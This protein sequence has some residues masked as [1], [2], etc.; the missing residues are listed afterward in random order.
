MATTE[1][2]TEPRT[3]TRTEP[4]AVVRRW[5]DFVDGAWVDAASGRT[6]DVVD[7]A[8]G[9]VVATAPVSGAA[10]VDA[11]YDAA[12]RAFETWRDTT[13]AEMQLALLRIADFLAAR[14]AEFAELEGQ[15]TG[16]PHARTAS[17]E[18]PRCVDQLR[19]FAGATRVLEWKSAGEYLAG[20]TS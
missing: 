20:H 7:P 14:S 11:A 16:K 12:A 1:H 18:L 8:T 6:S 5:R 3:E 15:E 19:S 2:R 17:E 4:A 9:R 13:P 10:D